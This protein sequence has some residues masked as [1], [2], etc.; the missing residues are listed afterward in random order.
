MIQLQLRPV[1]GDVYELEK[2][3]IRSNPYY[4]IKF[5]WCWISNCPCAGL[6]ENGGLVLSRRIVNRYLSLSFR[7]LFGLLS[8]TFVSA[9]SVWSSATLQIFWD[10]NQSRWLLHSSVCQLCHS[11]FNHSTG[12]VTTEKTPAKENKSSFFTEVR[13][14]TI[15][16]SHLSSPSHCGLILAWKVELVGR[17]LISTWKKKSAAGK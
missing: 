4:H 15:G 12:N 14:G 3:H 9:G 2:V 11:P 1:Q 5:L 6:T 8:L 16:H 13:Q 17:E 10:T 7:R